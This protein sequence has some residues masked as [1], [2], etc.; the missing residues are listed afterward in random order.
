MGEFWD[1]CEWENSGVC[2]T[3]SVVHSADHLSLNADDIGNFA[4][5]HGVTAGI[6][7]LLHE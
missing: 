4:L 7:G 6:Q 2:M 1:M 3:Y 5:E